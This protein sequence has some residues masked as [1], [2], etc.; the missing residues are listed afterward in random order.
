MIP[1]AKVTQ[2]E[3]IYVVRDD[4][5]KGGTKRAFVGKLIYGYE[6]V[7]YASPVYGGAQIAIAHAAK[8][9]GI[10]ATIICAKRKKPHARTL[11]AKNAG[12]K[13]I[14]VPTGYLSNIKSKARKYCE[15][16]GAYLLPFGLE[17]QLAFTA[18]AARAAKVQKLVGELDE[19]WCVAGS[20]VLA[21]G[22]QLGLDAKKFNC[23]QIGR[24]LHQ[25]DVGEAHVYIHP[26][27]FSKDAKIN[28]PF[29]S[30]SNYDA[31][32]WEYVIKQGKGKRL[33][34]NVMA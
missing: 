29:P 20:G 28:P 34:W 1:D 33:F 17:S 31:K 18:I 27:D 9:L 16:S 10:K 5:I 19:V 32:A 6:E 13:V 3:G 22:L 15:M 7:V 2:H 11:E 14:Q 23:V 25:S 4:L 30:C 8:D 24:T 12:A 21:R 26:F